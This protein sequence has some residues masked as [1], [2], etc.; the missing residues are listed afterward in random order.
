MMDITRK[1]FMFPV[2]L[3]IVLVGF[4]MSLVMIATGKS[5]QEEWREMNLRA[6]LFDGKNW[7]A[8]G[9]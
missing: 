2:R 5:W 7:N 8:A 9:F 1:Y 6:Y 3:G 4:L